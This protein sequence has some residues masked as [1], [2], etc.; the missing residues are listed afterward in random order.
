MRSLPNITAVPSLHRRSQ[1]PPRVRR[2]RL[3]RFAAVMHILVR[4]VF[5]LAIIS[6]PL[7]FVMP[8]VSPADWL[9]L[10]A[11]GILLGIVWG[12]SASAVRCSVCSMKLLIHQP[13]TKHDRA[14]NW[15]V[16]GYHGTLAAL[17]LCSRKVRC[18]YCG[19]PNL[20]AGPADAK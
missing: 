19:T 5:A 15:P 4:L 16:L 14:P 17:S 11:V 13:C 3:L 2:P 20:L 6:A 10:P 9:I 8:G 18:P 12:L 1:Q 7:F